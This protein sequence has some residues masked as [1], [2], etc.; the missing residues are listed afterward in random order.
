MKSRLFVIG[1]VFISLFIAF[2]TPA[3]SQSGRMLYELRQDQ[4]FRAAP[5]EFHRDAIALSPTLREQPPQPGEVMLVPAGSAVHPFRITHVRE[6]IPGILSFTG[7]DTEGAGRFMAFSIEGDR[8]VGLMQLLPEGELYVITPQPETS[9]NILARMRPDRIDVLACGVEDGMLEEL[10]IREDHPLQRARRNVASHQAL[11]APGAGTDLSSVVASR[12][13]KVTIDIMMV[14]TANAENWALGGPGSIQLVMAQAMNLSQQALDVSDT[15]IELRLVHSLKLAYNQDNDNDVSSSGVSSSIHLRRL[16]AAPNFNP[17]GGEF[18]GF[19]DEVHTLREVYGADMVTML[20]RVSDTGGIAWLLNTYA[21]NPGLGFSLNRIQQSTTGYTVVH[22]LGHNMGLAHG[23]QQETQNAGAFGGIHMYSAGWIFQATEP[24]SANLGRPAGRHT[25]MS[26]STAGSLDYPGFSNPEITSE[27]SLTG[28]VV[29]PIGPADAARSLRDIKATMAQYRPTVVTPPVKSVSIP[30]IFLS[31]AQGESGVVPFTVG[32]LGESN[33]FWSSEVAFR[34]E[35]PDRR[36][37]AEI[38]NFPDNHTVYETGFEAAQNFQISTNYISV[39]NFRSFNTSRNFQISGDNP[40]AG[41]SQHLRLAHLPGVSSEGFAQVAVPLFERSLA[42]TMTVEFDMAVQG[43]AGSRYDVYAFDVS[44][45]LITAG[46]SVVDGTSFSTISSTAT[47]ENLFQNVDGNFI[48]PGTYQRF[49]MTVVP[50]TGHVYFFVD[51]VLRSTMEISL[52]QTPDQI[53]FYRLNGSNT[54]D[55]MDIDNLRHI[56]H[57]NGYSWLEV[58]Q[59]SGSSR[60]GTNADAQLRFNASGMAAGSYDGAVLVRSN[61]PSQPVLTI[62]V[63]LR[64]TEGASAETVP[65]VAS[66]AVSGL[67]TSTATIAAEVTSD[68]NTALVTR[69]VCFA[70]TPNPNLTDTCVSE[71]AVAAGPYTITLRTLDVGVTYYARPFATNAIG[72]GYGNVVSFTTVRAL[73][74]VRTL[75]VAEVSPRG[76]VINAQLVDAG[77]EPVTERGV[78]YATTENPTIAA[79]CTPSATATEAFTVSL[80]ELQ[81]DTQY[82]ARAYATSLAGTSYGEQI[83]FRTTITIPE[84]VALAQN[85]PNPFNPSTSIIF[86]LPE[87]AKVTLTVYDVTGKKVVTLADGNFNAGNHTVRFNAAGLA[88]GLYFYALVTPEKVLHK[89]MLLIR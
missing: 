83:G 58:E 24:F 70:V 74:T 59:G 76:A 65:T 71:D 46:I 87:A 15:H 63:T 12:S 4:R 32:N 85:Y 50:E 28:N 35:A 19:M 21:G 26:Y 44:S 38:L 11:R 40:A 61:D 51:G 82:F 62:P 64:V 89:K 54:S 88:S 10:D 60:S 31:L 42:S 27:G 6:F 8:V 80:S 43:A 84:A 57:F 55:Y 30:A 81:E 17:F 45:G 39:N 7:V 33:L 53:T 1:V 41:S 72:T 56:R 23:R 13:D 16:S 79:T 37:S 34:Q 29:N 49:R 22:E 67:S 77:S 20:A 47:G 66:G 78:C 36:T 25:V 69:G 9:G 2:T 86:G 48:T 52:A 68:G 5:D 73:A 75:E 14:Y 3:W 18:A